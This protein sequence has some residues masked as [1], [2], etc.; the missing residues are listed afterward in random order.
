M[1]KNAVE[2][3]LEMK[4]TA[5]PM[6]SFG[7]SFGRMA[8]RAATG[9]LAG[10]LGAAAAGG[11]GMAVSKIVD[12]ATKSHDFKSMLEANQ[13]LHE[14]YQADPKRFNMMFS[15][16]RTMNPQFSKDPLVAGTFMRRMV[17]SPQGIG[18]VATEAL[19]SHGDFERP[20]SEAFDRG[21]G[22]GTRTGLSAHAREEEGP[23]QLAGE[24]AKMDY[25]HNLR[26]QG[27]EA[28]RKSDEGVEE[29]TTSYDYEQPNAQGEPKMTRLQ[30]K[31]RNRP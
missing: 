14:H 6:G 28:K 22:E 29:H 30:V 13:D 18:G 10:G 15:T 11:I 27:D 12:A 9:A 16:L 20:I 25:Q 4:K 17:L 3:V 23:G 1:G 31:S 24:K 26:M 8:G 7:S 5:G 19:H 21:I 2:E